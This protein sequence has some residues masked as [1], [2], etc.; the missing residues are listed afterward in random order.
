MHEFW[1]SFNWDDLYLS[2]QRLWAILGWDA[3]KWTGVPAAVMPASN[4]RAWV[5]LT[6]VEQ[7][8][9][10]AL[11]YDEN[12]WNVQLPRT[13]EGDVEIFW[14]QFG[15]DELY[16]GEQ[17]LYAY[18]GWNEASWSGDLPVPESEYRTW[19]ELSAVEQGAATQLGF[20]AASWDATVLE[21]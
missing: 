11:G 18:L 19:E 5:Q 7:G 2:E 4:W 17:Q 14:S 6:P 8:A 20:D 16:A 15:W 1:K 10:S 12:S 3:D 21:H 9:A 13:P